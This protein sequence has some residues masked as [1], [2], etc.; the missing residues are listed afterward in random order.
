MSIVLLLRSC[1]YCWG[2]SYCLTWKTRKTRNK[3]WS[4]CVFNYFRKF[5][6]V[7]YVKCK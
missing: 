3:W 1:F 5:C 6:K 7:L 2:C 4:N